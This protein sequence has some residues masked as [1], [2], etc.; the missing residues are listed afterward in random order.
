MKVAVI[1]KFVLPFI[2]VLLM[3]LSYQCKN[4]NQDFRF[5]SIKT[6]TKR[7]RLKT[8][9]LFLR[10]RLK[11]SRLYLGLNIW[12]VVHDRIIIYVCFLFFT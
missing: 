1:M 3:S 6:K 11:V 5:F 8:P 9:F 7:P 2:S 10:P 4:K 12:F